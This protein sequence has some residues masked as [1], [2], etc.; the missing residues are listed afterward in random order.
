LFNRLIV[1]III[2]IVYFTGR[3][4]GDKRKLVVDARKQAVGE[5]TL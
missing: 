4:S 5:M 2:V 3:G 1:E